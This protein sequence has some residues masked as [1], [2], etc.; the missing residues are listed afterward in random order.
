[1][2]VICGL[3]PARLA[4]CGE[5]AARAGPG[6]RAISHGDFLPA[7]VGKWESQIACG[8]W[9]G[10]RGGYEAQA[11]PRLL[12]LPFVL[13]ILSTLLGKRS[14]ASCSSLSAITVCFVLLTFDKKRGN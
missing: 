4:E 3:T 13:A 9:R 14:V 8:G 12:L 11:R 10:E 1:M 7:G 5:C 2:T 6:V